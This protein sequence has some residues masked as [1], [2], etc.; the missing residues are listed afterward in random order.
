MSIFTTSAVALLAMAAPASGPAQCI[1]LGGSAIANAVSE[2][3]FVGALEDRCGATK[4]FAILGCHA[5]FVVG[6]FALGDARDLTVDLFHFLQQVLMLSPA[7]DVIA[8]VEPH[9]QLDDLANSI[10]D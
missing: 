6:S 9:A 2:T 7:D 8:F 10:N 5:I 3:G 4:Q 1:D